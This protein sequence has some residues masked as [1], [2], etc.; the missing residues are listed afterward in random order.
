MQI[1]PMG[2]NTSIHKRIMTPKELHG[3]REGGGVR[4]Q[5]V[6]PPDTPLVDFYQS[7][8]N[9]LIG[10]LIEMWGYKEGPIEGSQIHSTILQGVL[11]VNPSL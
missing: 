9:P 8:A 1:K 2:S 11:P 6:H 7:I 5:G 10:V 3:A 4:P